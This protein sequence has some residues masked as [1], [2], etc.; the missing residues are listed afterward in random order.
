MTSKSKISEKPITIHTSRT[1][2]SAELSEVLDYPKDG[3][4]Y[5]D[6]MENNVFN[7]RTESSRK[8]TI[9]YLN[10]LY[11]L[12]KDDIRFMALEDY[13]KR[14]GEEDK[15]LLILLFAVS[16]DYL[17]KESVS[18]VKAV[19]INEK[20]YIEGFEDNI[21]QKHPNRFSPKTLR[22]VAQNI[23]S[24]WKQAGYIEGKVKNLRVKRSPSYLLVSFAF[25][26]AY[27]DGARGEY[28]TDHTSVKALDV[29]KEELYQLI[30]A[31][32]DRDLVRYNKS[33]ATMVISFENYVNRLEDG[34]S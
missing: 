1:I 24:S 9:R 17:L 25:L 10:Q 15:A 20:A 7:K 22:S 19:P 14:I 18:L 32:A 3:L 2:M 16:K 30:K 29:S 33:G 21:K 11:G 13:W 23:A 5:E 28:M 4:T 12:N 26:M 6:I 8:K 31:A 27:I 34:K